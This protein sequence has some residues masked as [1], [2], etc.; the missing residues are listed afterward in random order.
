ME[1]LPQE[2]NIYQGARLVSTVK[3]TLEDEARFIAW[4]ILALG[5]PASGE[6]F[7]SGE[8]LL[9]WQIFRN[10]NPLYLE[11]CVWTHKLSRQTGD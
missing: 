7:A 8:T 3:I 5:R 11:K 4:E 6:G 1:W 10:G 2:T 9:K